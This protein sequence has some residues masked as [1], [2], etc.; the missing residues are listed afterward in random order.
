MTLAAGEPA[1]DARPLDRVSI[2]ALA[3][4]HLAVDFAQGAV[5]AM[6]PFFVLERHFSYA[7]A[8][9]LVLAQT[10]SSSVVQPVFG[11]L[12]DRWPL[13]WLMPAGVALAGL[14]LGAAGL[15]PT[16]T[17]VWLSIAAGGLGVAALHP[18]AARYANYAAGDRR[19]TGLAV[20]QVGGNAGFAL[21]PLLTTPVLL[22]LGLGGTWALALP[23]L[24]IAGL[25]IAVLSRIHGHRPLPTGGAARATAAQQPDRPWTFARLTGAMVLR[26]VIFYGLNTFLPLYWIAVLHQTKGAAGLALTVLLVAGGIGTLVGG[27]LAERHS[28]RILIVGGCA[29][30][31]PLILLVTLSPSA[32]LALPLLVPLALALYIPS[33]PL[34]LSGQEY[35]PSSVGTASGVTLGLAVSAGG[36]VTPALGAVAD[37]AG[38]RPTMLLLA[39]VPVLLTALGATLPDVRRLPAA[40]RGSRV[41][42]SASGG[43]S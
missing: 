6:L 17:A 9:G 12:A 11:R 37:R 1:L 8:A 7:A 35:L 25:L 10:V 16:Y 13:P 34:V 31:G 23:G 24:A 15:L 38:L 3:C 32:L 27:R 2:G 40:G 14:G 42:R 4:G 36:V 19:S 43:P 18:E 33:S 22:V 28:R 29:L 20:F 41:R 30:T 39:V 21:G 26:S 5:P